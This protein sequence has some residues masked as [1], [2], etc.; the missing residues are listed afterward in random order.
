MKKLITIIGLGI[1][2]CPLPVTLAAPVQFTGDISTHYERDTN[3]G[4]ISTSGM[5]YTAKLKGEI[6]FGGDLSGYLRL[7]AQH[8][9]TPGFG[10]FNTAPG[11]YD[12]DEKSVLAFDQIGLLY[13]RDKLVY[14]LGRQEAIVGTT[15]LLYSRSDSKIGKQV[16]VDGLTISGTVGVMDVSALLAQE[17]NIG[18]E[19]NKVYALRFGYHPY[20]NLTLGATLGRY[21][22][23]NITATNHWAVDTTY[24]F[25]NN[26]IVAEFTKSSSHTNNTAYAATWNYK[27]DQQ[28]TAY[29]T[30]F[31][32]EENSDMGGQSDFANDNRGFDYGIIHKLNDTSRIEAIY[33][34]Q[35]TISGGETSNKIDLTFIHEF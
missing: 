21:Q 26:S 8:L 30:G 6:D 5:V 2:L 14:K 24:N 13:K 32:V 19:D 28:T 10:D 33:E 15:A 35:K 1:I 4:V 12:P 22:G 27:F 18:C 7:G 29:I 34:S 3:D 23:V 31:K 25:G 11:S 9:T 16:F 17:D 20:D